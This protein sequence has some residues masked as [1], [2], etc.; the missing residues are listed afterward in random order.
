MEEITWALGMKTE[1]VLHGVKGERYI[2]VE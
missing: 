2:V 1:E